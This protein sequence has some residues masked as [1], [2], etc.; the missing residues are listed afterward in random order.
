MGINRLNVL[1]DFSLLPDNVKSDRSSIDDM[2]GHVALANKNIFKRTNF[3][4]WNGYIA[5][6]DLADDNLPPFFRLIRDDQAASLYEWVK[7]KD[8]K[9]KRLASK[10]FGTFWPYS[11]N[12]NGTALSAKG[13]PI[14]GPGYKGTSTILAATW[15]GA[16]DGN[17]G[18]GDW[19]L[20]AWEDAHLPPTF[21]SAG[22]FMDPSGFDLEGPGGVEK[23]NAVEEEHDLTEEELSKRKREVEE[24]VSNKRQKLLDLE[25]PNNRSKME[26]NR[27]IISLKGQ[28]EIQKLD[29]KASP[30]NIARIKELQRTIERQVRELNFHRNQMALSKRTFEF[31]KDVAEQLEEST[32]GDYEVALGDGVFSSHWEL[33]VDAPHVKNLFGDKVELALTNAGVAQANHPKNNSQ[34]YVKGGSKQR[35]HVPPPA[36]QTL[37][38]DLEDDEEELDEAGQAEINLLK[39]QLAKAAKEKIATGIKERQRALDAASSMLKNLGATYDGK[40]LEMDDA[41]KQATL[42]KKQQEEAAAARE[43]ENEEFRKNE[44]TRQAQEAAKNREEAEKERIARKEEDGEKLA[45]ADK[46]KQRIIREKQSKRSQG[47]ESER[48]KDCKGKESEWSKQGEVMKYHG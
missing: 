12:V 28:I 31:M 23:E 38:I 6:N 42:K 46:E 41:Q 22:L 44:E 14:F 43:R 8:N 37:T 7:D 13:R 29:L 3:K 17:D 20:P 40:P 19:K 30:S 5:L 26:L 1:P 15:S 18:T 39:E 32:D 21:T 16:P 11:F 48:R 10:D 2:D 27:M 35:Y 33:D 25:A 34:V 45:A 24:L 9:E 4:P 36:K 47:K